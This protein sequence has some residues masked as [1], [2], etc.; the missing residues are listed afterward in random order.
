MIKQINAL[1]TIKIFFIVHSPH[2][3]NFGLVILPIIVVVR[4]TEPGNYWYILL[5]V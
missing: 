3:N 1:A 4:I 5:Y 2:D